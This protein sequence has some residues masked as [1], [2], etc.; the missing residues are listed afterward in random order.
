[1]VWWS[2]TMSPNTLTQGHLI[3]IEWLFA[4]VTFVGSHDR[5]ERANLG[6]ILSVFWPIQA[7]FVVGEPLLTWKS[8][9]EPSNLT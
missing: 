3:K 8:P 7:A 2:T 9:F 6:M 1:M 5:G 4:D